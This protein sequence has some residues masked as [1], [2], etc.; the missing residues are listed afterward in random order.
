MKGMQLQFDL[1]QS[2]GYQFERTLYYMLVEHFGD[3]NQTAKAA[4]D[5]SELVHRYEDRL[6]QMNKHFQQIAFD[7]LAL[8]PPR[9][10]F[11]KDLPPID[12][13]KK[14]PDGDQS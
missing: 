9:P 11:A 13:T 14:N 5:I 8:D 7:K 1:S 10:I 3:S 2:A 4:H 6:V 12:I